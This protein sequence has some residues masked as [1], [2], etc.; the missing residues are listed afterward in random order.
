MSCGEKQIIAL[1]RVLVH[2]PSILIMDEATSHID[3][4]TEVMIKK[5]WKL[6]LRV[7]L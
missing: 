1:A 4:E 7:E 3:T 5:H 2:N 6:L